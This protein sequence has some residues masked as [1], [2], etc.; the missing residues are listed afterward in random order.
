LDFN[1]G[2]LL[3]LSNI[4]ATLRQEEW[5]LKD[6]VGV[7]KSTVTY[8]VSANLLTGI[9]VLTVSGQVSILEFKNFEG[10]T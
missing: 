8:K 5:E 2:K 3:Y 9:Y 1:Y 6:K 7:N 10:I 4:E